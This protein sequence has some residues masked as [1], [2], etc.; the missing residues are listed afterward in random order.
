M[1][2]YDKPVV[3]LFQDLIKDL[4]LSKGDVISRNKI[5]SWF[6]TNYPLVKPATVSAHLLKLST[7][8][9]TRIHYNAN[10]NGKDDL[11]FQIDRKNFRLYDPTS[12]PEPIYVKQNINDTIDEA[13]TT[14]NETYENEFAYEKDLQNFLAKN[15]SLIEPGL[16]LY[17]EEDINGVEF[18]V[19]NRYI[20]ILAVDSS[21]NYVVI[22]LK[23]SRAYDKVVGQLLRY[24]GWIK[25]HH[26]EPNQS[27]RG[28]IIAREISND[29]LLACSGLANIDLY[30]Y[31]LSVTL[32]NI[33]KHKD[34]A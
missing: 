31:N 9:P 33:K 22:E 7:N 4:A 29:L 6:A 27:V 3:L 23:V 12:D 13:D 15:L 2:L 10:P 24:M 14:S 8:A 17:M 32:N 21:N 11:F 16:I 1:A 19:G 20:D 18:P 34:M 28:I 30:E 25:K 26:A 5:V